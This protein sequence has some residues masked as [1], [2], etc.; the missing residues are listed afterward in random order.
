VS[1]VNWIGSLSKLVTVSLSYGAVSRS[2]LSKCGSIISEKD[3]TD[4]D[5]C[6]TSSLMP[7]N[8]GDDLEI[9]KSRKISEIHETDEMDKCVEYFDIMDESRNCNVFLR[10]Y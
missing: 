10:Y 9:E 7:V 4:K 3:V 6:Q 2:P 5:L 1:S 8:V